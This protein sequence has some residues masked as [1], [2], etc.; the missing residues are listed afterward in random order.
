MSPFPATGI[1]A[2]A[3]RLEGSQPGLVVHVIQGLPARDEALVS[4][5]LVRVLESDPE[6][7]AMAW[8]PQLQQPITALVT[9]V[10]ALLPDVKVQ[11]WGGD[12]GDLPGQ[13]RRLD[14]VELVGPAE[15]IPG[16][17]PRRLGDGA[18]S[19][20]TGQGRARDL[21]VRVDDPWCG[22]LT[23]A[24]AAGQLIPLL[25][26]GAAVW[27]D[28][29][30]LTGNRGC[31]RHLLRRLPDGS[32]PRLD[33][34]LP[35][36]HMDQELAGE[37]ARLGI[38]RVTLVASDKPSP[39]V[40]EAV[41]RARKVGV[42]IGVRLTYGSPGH[43]MVSLRLAMDGWL[44]IGLDDLALI[45]FT[46]TPPRAGEAAGQPRGL[47]VAS[48][49]PH[50][51]L[52]HDLM[53]GEE[54]CR[55]GWCAA[56]LER[57][58]PLVVGTGLPRVLQANQIPL[59]SILE[60]L[61]EQLKLDGHDLTADPGA[62]QLRRG[63]VR[64]LRQQHGLDLDHL[65]DNRQAR[66]IRSPALTL[67][68]HGRG[69]VVTDRDTGRTARLGRGALRLL[70]RFCDP[71]SL[72]EVKTDLL[73][74]VE[75]PRRATLERDLRRTADKLQAMGFIVPAD[76]AVSANAGEVSFSS[77]EEFDYHNRMLADRARGEAYR[78]AIMAAVQPGQHV[79][80]VGTGTGILAVWAAQAG[81]RV[82]AI[83]RYPVIQ[84]AEQLARDNGVSHRI[85]LIRGRSDLVRLDD[86]GDMLITE[87]VGNRILNE[88]ILE[89]TLDCRR[90]LLRP[91]ATL[92][93]GALEI[94]VRLVDARRFDPVRAE[95]S[96]LGQQ[97]G[98]KLDVIERWLDARLASGRL[99]W[100]QAPG[101][102]AFTSLTRDEVVIRLDFAAMR[103]A[104]FDREVTLTPGASGVA[105]GALLSFRLE[106]QPGEVIS[107][108]Q[109][110]HGLHWSRPVHMLPVPVP[111][112]AGEA[113]RLKVGYHPHGEIK[114]SLAEE[115]R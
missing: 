94:L 113:V 33:L 43:D 93:P 77:L 70:D 107:S 21:P 86:P 11:L 61:S 72:Q 85:K 24:E 25:T 34:H 40:A 109:D 7:L 81:A 3:A 9:R 103:Q 91:G 95:L 92:L 13:L 17:A 45:P 57:L 4:A 102:D 99:I 59:L 5:A 89:T 66:L 52:A 74:A 27:L 78:R 111:C 44:G 42:A 90:R 31:L 110:D 23:V 83:E 108:S 41:A 101:D 47:V 65:G 37:M 80:E 38:L 20:L 32:A 75:A 106:L 104:G 88:G 10:L 64:Y 46:V 112:Q 22:R 53:S 55:L 8:E 60:G 63:L 28:H 100:E 51:V 30:K 62:L 98:V 18:V 68:W 16:H 71:R 56:L 76:G 79:V 69:R 87:L 50:E 1:W 15:A 6:V 105:N 67:K 12:P 82:T 96:H 115:T 58:Q 2:L 26:A 35:A 19:A 14:G 49:P 48:T 73:E 97:Y 29:P 54:I 39:A 114:V 36:R 84:I